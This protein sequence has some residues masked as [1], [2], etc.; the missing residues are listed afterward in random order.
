MIL[1]NAIIRLDAV[2]AHH[3]NRIRKWRCS[4]ESYKYFFEFKLNT[5]GEQE[6][7]YDN[8]LKNSK[9]ELFMIVPVDEESPNRCPIGMLG[10]QNIDTRNRRAEFGRFFI[11]EKYRKDTFGTEALGVLLEYGVNHLNLRRVYCYA[12]A[13]NSIAVNL[14][15]S[16][17]FQVEGTLRDHIYKNG[18]YMDVVIMGKVFT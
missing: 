6:N 2:E 13:D 17:F 18:R 11:E 10:F 3:L 15:L 7:W 12:L 8:Y 16:Q 1:E 5:R 14:Y 4:R 9:E